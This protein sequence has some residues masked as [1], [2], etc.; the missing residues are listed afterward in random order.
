MV[1]L[2]VVGQASGRIRGLLRRSRRSSRIASLRRIS[3]PHS[4]VGLDRRAAKEA[5][6]DFL[7]N[8]RLQGNQIE[9]VN[10]IVDSL[11]ERGVV[12]AARLY[13]S[14]FTDVAPSGAFRQPGEVTAGEPS[15]SL[16]GAG[17]HPPS[18]PLASRAK[19]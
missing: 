2:S 4:L 5:F 14:P 15:L 19:S 3:V 12:E 10:M 1:R 8:H 13:E 11:A 7:S 6:A 9:F 18:R 17:G 16:R